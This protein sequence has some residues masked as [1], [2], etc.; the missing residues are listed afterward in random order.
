MLK[1][2]RRK[3]FL[4]NSRVCKIQI[5]INFVKMSR[6]D[7]WLC[8]EFLR[9]KNW[10]VARWWITVAKTWKNETYYS[11]FCQLYKK[12]QLKHRRPCKNSAV[13]VFP[14]H[15]RELWAQFLNR[16]DAMVDIFL[17]K[18]AG[19]NSL[20]ATAMNFSWLLRKIP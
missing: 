4:I 17:K 19:L 13:F 7:T 15:D 11:N 18:S 10:V 14:M 6:F 16:I 3:V 12:I 8:K 1:F 9:W 2:K 20:A 5:L